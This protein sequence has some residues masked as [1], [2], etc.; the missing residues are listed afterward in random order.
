[1]PMF[2]SCNGILVLIS[3][4]LQMKFVGS[5]ALWISLMEDDTPIYIWH[6]SAFDMDVLFP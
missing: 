2:I 6:M 5:F 4:Q 1:M 3:F